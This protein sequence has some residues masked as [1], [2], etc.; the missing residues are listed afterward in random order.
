MP[1]SVSPK[2]KA[3]AAS[4]NAKTYIRRILL[5]SIIAYLFYRLSSIGW[6]DIVQAL[7]SAPAFYF[8][9]VIAFFAPVIAE[10]VAFKWV[11]AHQ[12][13]APL[14]V[15]IRK[16]VLNKAVLA[17]S[18]EAYL[19]HELSQRNKLPLKRAATIIKDLALVRTFVANLWVIILVVAAL[20]LGNTETLSNIARLSPALVI[21][22]GLICVTICL[23]AVIF[24][25]NL[26]NLAFVTGAKIAGVFLLRSVVVASVL[27]AQWALAIPGTAMSVWFLFLVVFVLAR[28]SP[29]GG[30][31]VFISVALALPGL[32]ADSAAIA[33]MLVTIMAL[34]QLNYF[35][36]FLITGNGIKLGL[37]GVPKLNVLIMPH[38]T[39]R[40]TN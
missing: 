2:L 25:K 1:Q 4:A 12:L 27:T 7:P 33:A 8:L 3:S 40:N 31:M 16:H 15:F 30:E 17:Y 24:F 11:T 13:A 34:N 5:V 20:L 29:I 39:L 36:A 14:G 35:L 6:Q 21:A 10:V 26:T 37:S 23:G 28:K 22:V 19:V 18:G 32:S 9:S 38:G